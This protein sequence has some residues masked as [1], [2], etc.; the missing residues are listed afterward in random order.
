MLWT[1]PPMNI[2]LLSHHSREKF[3]Q[4][5]AAWKV[6][7]ERM[8]IWDDLTVLDA[9]LSDNLMNCYN[10]HKDLDKGL[11][12]L[13]NMMCVVAHGDPYPLLSPNVS[14]GR[15]IAVLSLSLIYFKN[16]LLSSNFQWVKLY[17]HFT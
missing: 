8:I 7:P 10:L 1:K 13:S 15:K 6:V 16:N 14:Q 2:L 11:I 3:L 12:D 17:H 9:I 5:I 4:I